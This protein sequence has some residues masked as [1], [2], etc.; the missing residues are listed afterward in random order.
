MKYLI[1]GGAG[2]IGGNYLL[3]AVP[4]H[5]EN[6]YVCLDALTYAGNLSTL[7]AI[8]KSTNFRFVHGNICNKKRIDSL[9][10]EYQFD[11]VIN[12][13]AETHVDR[14]SLYPDL[15]MR[16]NLIGTQTLLDACRKFEIKRYHQVSTDE[17][18]GDL[19]LEKKDLFFT[20]ESPIR[21]SSPYSASK[22][23]AD[24]LCLAY[25]R[26][27][28]LP[29]T[30]SR[31]SNNYGPYQY[32]EKLIPLMIQKAR[33]NQELPIYGTGNNVRDWLFVSDH[34]SAIDTI[35]E[36][37]NVGNIY[38]VG[39]HNEQTNLQ[40]VHS[41]LSK[42]NKSDS[43]IRFVADR[44]G[45]D[46]RYAIDPSKIRSLGWSDSVPFNEGIKETIEWNIQNEKWLNSVIGKD[47]QTFFQAYYKNR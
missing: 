7:T 22:A 18:Y 40:I 8:K 9:F 2:F 20:E 39:S 15:F 13:A 35:I 25:Y 16:T 5:P 19:P 12:F 30:I 11:Y 1:T 4:K 46:L 29:I 28:G 3:R 21:P 43:L 32:P 41:I 34:C 26:T 45:H 38:N 36:K 33:N 27:Y 14:A 23:S 17:V 31:C 24:L 47:A 37:G 44:P 42:M 10:R 6:L